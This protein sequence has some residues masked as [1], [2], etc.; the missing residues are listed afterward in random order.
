MNDNAPK[1]EKGAN[2]GQI[3]ENERPG[4]VIMTVQATD[5]DE[6]PAFK[7]VNLLLFTLS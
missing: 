4:T 5:A 3:F 2:F 1:F 7:E 6:T